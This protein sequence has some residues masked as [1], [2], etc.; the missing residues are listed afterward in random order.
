MPANLED[1]A[2]RHLIHHIYV[3]PDTGLW[4][5]NLLCRCKAVLQGVG[6]EADGAVI[7]A[8]DV[9]AKHVQEAKNVGEE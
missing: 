6:A 1:G 3:E 7:G 2:E 9:H 5:A 8:L 4:Y